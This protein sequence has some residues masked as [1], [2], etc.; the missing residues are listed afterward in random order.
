MGAFT[1]NFI[2]QLG[3]KVTE[4]GFGVSTSRLVKSMNLSSDRLNKVI[5]QMSTGRKLLR[6]G[7]E[8]VNFERA[9]GL[10]LS[11]A[12]EQAQMQGIQ[13]QVTWH[14]ISIEKL[15]TINDML[16]RMSGIAMQ[17][18][19]SVLAAGDQLALDEDFQRMK[20]EISS[21]VDGGSGSGVPNA[22]FA[23]VPLFLGYVPGA[24]LGP[25]AFTAKDSFEGSNLYT[26]HAAPGFR[27]LPFTAGDTGPSQ[28]LTLT[29]TAANTLAS[30]TQITLDV[31]AAGI[32]N[33]Y[34]GL[35]IEITTDVLGVSTTESGT[36]S[37]YD[38][39]SRIATLTTPLS[40]ITADSTSTYVVKSDQTNVELAGMGGA[41][42]L[43]FAEHVWGA[44]NYRLDRLTS[45]VATFVPL[46]EEESTYRATNSIPTTDTAPKTG[47]EKLA[48]RKLNIFDPQYGN[49][50]NPENSTRMLAQVQ[51][52]I[53]QISIIMTRSDAKAANL[54]EQFSF[55]QRASGHHS[56]AE[57]KFSST[58]FAES[59]VTYDEL[60][61]AHQQ[62][63]AVATRLNENFGLLTRLVRRG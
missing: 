39:A 37:S 42:S 27:D 62:I 45:S 31:N 21:M 23:G 11:R 43:P 20:L 53:D 19:S 48:R 34:A 26:G 14:Q 25:E 5:N 55:L 28:Q 51:R 44:D 1:P 47:A 2:L 17:A 57:K 56:E 36:I 6:P 8:V 13:S 35:Q 7:D 15:G 16:T 50:K 40:T 61:T 12:R 29:G 10:G 38:A 33:V 24:E 3:G 54:Q 63:I 46:T 22:S 32:D 58:D 30:A 41:T 18:K 9:R 52:A 60:V 4:S 49:V 59:G